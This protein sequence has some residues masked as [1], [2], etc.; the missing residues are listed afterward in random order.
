M[1]P[2]RRGSLKQ[3]IVGEAGGNR[4]ARRRARG[5]CRRPEAL[6]GPCQL[7]W[8]SPPAFQWYIPP[9]VIV[10]LLEVAKKLFADSAY[11]P[12]LQDALK[13]LGVSELIEIVPKPKGAKDL[14]SCHVVG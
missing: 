2:A 4:L 14:Q 1:Q 5:S 12:K 6:P 10:A 8:K 13:E 3:G 11:A 9:A 7:A